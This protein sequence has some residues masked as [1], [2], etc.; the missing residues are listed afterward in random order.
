MLF[1]REINKFGY[2]F[3]W[4][5]NSTPELRAEVAWTIPSFMNCEYLWFQ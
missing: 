2:H 1:R 5:I 3:F 4:L